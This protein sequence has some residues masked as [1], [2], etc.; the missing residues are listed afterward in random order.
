LSEADRDVIGRFAGGIAGDLAA[1][2]EGA[3]GLE[4]AASEQIVPSPDPF[5]GAGGLRFGI[6]DRAGRPLLD[7][8]IPSFA[9]TAFRKAAISA[10]RRRAAPLVPLAGAVDEGEV[11]VV[12]RLG[13][14]VLPLADLAGLA[15][16]DV[17]VL[18]RAIEDGAELLFSPRGRPFARGA[19]QSGGGG[20]SLLLTPSQ[21]DK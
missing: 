19:I 11:R 17:L 9:L 8:A 20:F 13:A 14:A 18:D 3:L 5:A 16:G 6:A 10:P 7:V 2:V 21:E 1:T 15:T 12:A 4:P